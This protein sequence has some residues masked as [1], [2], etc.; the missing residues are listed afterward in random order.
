MRRMFILWPLTLISCA[1]LSRSP[2]SGYATTD[3][4]VDADGDEF[5]TEARLAREAREELG[6]GER[7]LTAT[8]RDALDAR[9]SLK[10]AEAAIPNRRDQKLYYKLRSNLRTDAEREYVL[11]LP[12]AAARS[13]Y[14][15]EHG[16]DVIDEAQAEELA[17]VIEA[18]DIAIGMTQKAVGE[19]WGDP[20]QV[21][22]AGDGVYGI[23]RWRYNR[24]VSGGDGYRKEIRLV[25]FEGGRVTGWE[26]P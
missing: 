10:R 18:K 4:A 16:L 2:R 17:A 9:V 21:E 20:D 5:R 8:E 1:T 6:L 13:R 15:T 23:E 22:T 3:A 26:R 24:Y 19:S 7:R 25:Y 12:T 14:V 11:G